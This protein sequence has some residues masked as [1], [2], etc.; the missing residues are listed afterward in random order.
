MKTLC[1]SSSFQNTP[2]ILGKLLGSKNS[3][4]ILPVVLVKFLFGGQNLV[5]ICFLQ[6]LPST[7]TTLQLSTHNAVPWHLRVISKTLLF[8]LHFPGLPPNNIILQGHLM[9]GLAPLRLQKRCTEAGRAE[10]RL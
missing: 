10:T 2:V 5:D 1:V 6:Q 4:S 8:I 3:E 7:Q 9:G